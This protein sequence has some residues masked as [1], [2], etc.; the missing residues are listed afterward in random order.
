MSR[1]S[2]SSSSTAPQTRTTPSASGGMQTPAPTALTHQQIAQR[3]YE[4]FL[5][6][7][8]QHG[9][10]QDDWYQ[11]ETELRLGKQ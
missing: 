4:I 6:R 10:D 2:K 7:G 1:Q 5:A 9:R 11:A 8:A 3:A